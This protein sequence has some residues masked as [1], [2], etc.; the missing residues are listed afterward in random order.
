MLHEVSSWK[1]AYICKVSSASSHQRARTYQLE[2]FLPV[3][4]QLTVSK[5]GCE[6]LTLTPAV[7]KSAIFSNGTQ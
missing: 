2:G 5:I 4:R 3:L 1:Q 7:K 6:E